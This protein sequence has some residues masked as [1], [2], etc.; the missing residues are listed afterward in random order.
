MNPHTPKWAPTLGIGIPMDFQTF[1]EQLQGSKFIGLKSFLHQQNL[2]KHRCLKWARMTHLDTSNTSYGQKKGWESNWQFNSR[3]LKVQN[4]PDLFACRWR[5]T[6]RWKAFDEG[7]NFA[8]DFISI[9]DLHAKLWAPKVARVPNVWISKLPL[10][11]PGTKWHLG[12]GLMVRHIVYYKGECGGFCEYLLHTFTTK[13]CTHIKP[14]WKW[15]YY[16][17]VV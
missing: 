9:G 7:Y 8:L 14:G 1:R 5:A 11:S 4:R 12:V 6:Y 13:V 10:G 15:N 16:V 2:L 17:V 3:P